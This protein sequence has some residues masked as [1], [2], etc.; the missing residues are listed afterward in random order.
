MYQGPRDGQGELEPTHLVLTAEGSGL[1]AAGAGRG[2]AGRARRTAARGLRA[3]LLCLM[4][5]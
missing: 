2:L 5:G 4:V 1:K 3:A